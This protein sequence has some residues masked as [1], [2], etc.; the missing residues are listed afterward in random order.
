MDD[1]FLDPVR[2]Y[3]HFHAQQHD[4]A[5]MDA[6]VDLVMDLYLMRRELLPDIAPYHHHNYLPAF[7]IDDFYKY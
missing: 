6:D 4:I 3:L 1:N 7:E 5:A 2:P